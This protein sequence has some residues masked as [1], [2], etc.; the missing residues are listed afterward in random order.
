[1]KNPIIDSHRVPTPKFI[2]SITS[3]YITRNKGE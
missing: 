1:V 2:E 3:S